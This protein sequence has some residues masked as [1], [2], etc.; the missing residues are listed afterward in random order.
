MLRH[1]IEK[2]HITLFREVKG[3]LIKVKWL[4]KAIRKLFDIF[5][6]AYPGTPPIT[7]LAIEINEACNRKCAWC[8]NSENSRKNNFL[9]EDV[10]YNIIDQMVKMKFIGRVTFNQYNEPLLDKRLPKFIR[11]IR[12]NL[13]SS[14]IYI[15]TNG[16]FMN[17]ELWNLL[18]KEGLDYANISQYD[19]KI[20]QN[21]EKVLECLDNEE[22]KHF[23]VNIF[24]IS[25]IN[26]RAGLV[27]TATELPLEKFCFRPFSQLSVTYEGKVVLCCNDYFGHVEVGDVRTTPIKE[28]WESEIFTRYRKELKKGNRADLE[29]CKTCDA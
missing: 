13:P 21:I 5:L 27:N 14:Y 8:P 11:Y 15:N 1:W 29:L 28:I 9:D 4:K 26:N 18:R 22:K 10:F 20:N 6:V 3:K 17:F 24:D 25:K 7:T 16:D 23:G 2:N 19:G 12:Q